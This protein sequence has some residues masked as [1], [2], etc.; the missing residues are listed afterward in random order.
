[1]ATKRRYS[2]QRKK[3][4]SA[5]TTEIF[6][7][8]TF[9]T[10]LLE[11]LKTKARE[12]TDDP[13]SKSHLELLLNTFDNSSLTGVLRNY[14]NLN[15]DSKHYKKYLENTNE[16]YKTL[17][18]DLADEELACT[19]NI[20]PVIKRSVTE[21]GTISD[22]CN[23]IVLN[24]IE[25]SYDDGKLRRSH[26][27]KIAD[28]YDNDNSSFRRKEIERFHNET[29]TRSAKLNDYGFIHENKLLAE[30]DNIVVEVLQISQREKSLSFEIDSELY[31]SLLKR[32]KKLSKTMSLI[33]EV[34]TA[35]FHIDSK[36]DTGSYR[37]YFDGLECITKSSESDR[38]MELLSEVY[39]VFNSLDR[40]N[41]KYVYRMFMEEYV[42]IERFEQFERLCSLCDSFGKDVREIF[43]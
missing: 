43:Q 25:R 41:F 22:S 19:I 39:Q 1:M 23:S 3:E 4:L 5:T 26:K 7:K 18:S 6:N 17:E 33:G 40:R 29:L 14:L 20:V 42:N 31:S 15:I 2:E 12:K 10:S 37:E 28:L 16:L 9:D 34:T 32:Y 27:L 35:L 36:G 11:T 24:V 38:Y 21:K 8:G 30:S 13:V